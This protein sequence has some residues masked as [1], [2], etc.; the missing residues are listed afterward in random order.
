M[1]KKG[2]L[3]FKIRNRHISHENQR[4]WKKSNVKHFPRDSLRI[5]RRVNRKILFFTQ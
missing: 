5:K 3:K 1:K 4:F 2:K